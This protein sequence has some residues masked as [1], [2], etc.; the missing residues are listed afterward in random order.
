M[1]AALP[2]A[3]VA[4]LMLGLL[5]LAARPHHPRRTAHHAQHGFAF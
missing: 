5:S 2:L 4:L 3:L 1:I